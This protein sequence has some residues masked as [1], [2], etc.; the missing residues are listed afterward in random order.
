[1]KL[2]SKLRYI[3]QTACDNSAFFSDGSLSISIRKKQYWAEKA[4]N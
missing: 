4:Y 1:M 3:P 2:L